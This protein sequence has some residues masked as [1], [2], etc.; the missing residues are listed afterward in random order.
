MR[1]TFRQLQ[2]FLATARFENVSRAAESLAMSQSAASGSLK[3]LE[4]QFEVQ[5]FDRLGKRLQLSE[6]GR[7]LRPQAERLL[8]QAQDFE[9][10]LSTEEGSGALRVGA[11][12]TI[13][14]Y[15]AVP[16]IAAFRERYTQAD[17]ALQVANTKTIAR[18]VA[19]FELD[20]G[21]IEGEINHPQLETIHW[22]EDELQVFAAPGHPLAGVSQ[23]SD[24]QLMSQRWI[25]RESGSGTRQAFERAMHGI[26]TDLDISMELQHTEAIKRAVEAGL[27]VACLSKISL[28]EAFQRGSLIPLDIPHRD[29]SRQL[30]LILQRDKFHT[31]TLERWLSLCRETAQ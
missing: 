19:D 27:G 14:N 30:N 4:Q 31:A 5:L 22:R 23:V 18:Q 13:G 21:M 8:A 3:E 12:L 26:L 25:M 24:D 9:A 2:V 17:V 28:K 20:L 1:F 7:Q 16:M 11:T 29:F 15:L 10:A 6:L